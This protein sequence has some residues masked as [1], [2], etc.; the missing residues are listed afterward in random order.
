MEDNYT[1]YMHVTPSNKIYV[2]LTCKTPRAR[3]NNGNN[4]STQLHFY[5]AIKKYGWDNIEH[6]IVAEGLS[7]EEAEILEIDLIKY[8]DT[9]NQGNGYNKSTGGK[10]F[11]GTG[12]IPVIQYDLNL[13]KIK[14]YKSVDCASKETG[15]PH[16]NIC[17]C[18]R[19]V[20]G[21][22]GGYVWRYKKDSE[23]FEKLIKDNKESVLQC[24]KYANCDGVVQYNLSGSKINTFHSIKEASEKTGMSKDCIGKSC[25]E[26]RCTCMGY[27]WRFIEDE[28]GLWDE[29][30][31]YDNKFYIKKH[32]GSKSIIQ[33]SKE[34]NKVCEFPSIVIAA[35]ENDLTPSQVSNVCRKNEITAGGYI[36]RYANDTASIAETVKRIKEART[37]TGYK[38]SKAVTQYDLNGVRIKEYPNV[39]VASMETGAKCS[40]ISRACRGLCKTSMGFIWKY[41]VPFITVNGSDE[42]P[43]A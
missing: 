35:K 31:E 17:K 22:A 32:K 30:V 42:K 25:H 4:Y 10:A 34:G 43:L 36:W 41:T 12:I 20:R 11:S 38:G 23:A 6:I 28:F 1:V 7:R 40:G 24:T 14:E 5:R 8:W 39:I 15:V 21:T 13:N 37:I 27:V 3:W 18:C 19:S 2:G 9:T 29:V 16:P 26:K 33:Y